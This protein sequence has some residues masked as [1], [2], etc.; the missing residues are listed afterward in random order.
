MRSNGIRKNA[1]PRAPYRNSVSRLTP[2]KTRE[3]NSSSGTSGARDRHASARNPLSS[4]TPAT[5]NPQIIGCV[6][7]RRGEND[8][9][10]KHP[11]SRKYQESAE[12]VEP[13][14]RVRVA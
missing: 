14:G 13:R 9:G 1:P 4:T 5:S 11:E 10:D 12:P 3:L 7:P 8:A 6:Q 2:E